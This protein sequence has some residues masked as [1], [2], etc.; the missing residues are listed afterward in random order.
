MQLS[1]PIDG[2]AHVVPTTTLWPASYT[3]DS[4][5]ISIRVAARVPEFGGAY[6]DGQ[7]YLI[8][9]VTDLS[10]A[11][12]TQQ[13]VINELLASGRESPTMRLRYGRYSYGELLL[14]KNALRPLLTNGVVMLTVDERTNRIVVA[15]T[16][17]PA[18]LATKIARYGV[19]MGAVTI[20][21]VPRIVQA[22]SVDGV[23]RPAVGGLRIQGFFEQSSVTWTTYCSYGTNVRD[24]ADTV[25]HYMVVASHCV[26]HSPPVG[27]YVGANVYQPDT[28]AL[29]ANLVGTVVA[30]PPFVGG[31]SCPATMLCRASDAALVQIEPGVPTTLGAVARPAGRVFLPRIYGPT[32]IDQTQPTFTLSGYTEA[33]VGDTVDKVGSVTGWTGGVVTALCADVVIDGYI[34]T[35][36]GV[37][38]GGAG[39]GDSGAPVMFKNLRGRYYVAGIL[40]GLT[41]DGTDGVSG[42]QYYFSTWQSVSDDLAGFSGLGVR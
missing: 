3:N 21:S 13:T 25:H 9:Y 19:P 28:V 12:I 1:A 15:T 42:R 18:V 30:N 14:W 34:R 26:Q 6:I 29:R 41:V 23:L 40:F 35:C 20:Q 4:R 27:G 17:A 31:G 38:S 11:T 2:I 36:S 16:G 7:G 5:A 33:L 37:V 39:I 24:F 8:A 22:G 10:R 32:E